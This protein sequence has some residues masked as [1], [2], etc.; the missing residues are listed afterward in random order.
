MLSINFERNLSTGV[1]DIYK[2]FKNLNS[3]HDLTDSRNIIAF[4]VLCSVLPKCAF[5]I[6]PAFHI[7]CTIKVEALAQ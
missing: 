5:T 4:A 7:P 1:T 6:S 2:E 3:F